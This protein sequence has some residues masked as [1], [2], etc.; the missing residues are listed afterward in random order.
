MFL[1]FNFTLIFLSLSLFITDALP[2]FM[3]ST[4]ESALRSQYVRFDG[5]V[6]N[7]R[8]DEPLTS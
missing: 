5:F 4:P 8:N 7:V 2:L 6:N 1:A 3:T